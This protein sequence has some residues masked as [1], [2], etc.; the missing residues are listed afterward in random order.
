MASVVISGDT[1]GSVTITAPAVA[2]TPTLTLPTATDTLIGR[3]TTDTL[4]NKS[5]VASQLTGTIAGARMPA[6]S[7]LQ[8]VNATSNA[9]TTSSSTTYADTGLTVS[10]TPTSSTSKILVFVSINGGYKAGSDCALCTRLVRDSTAISNIDGMTLYTGSTAAAGGTVSFNYLDSPAT[11][12]ST[13][14]KVQMASSN[15]GRTVQINNYISF[16]GSVSA[17]TVMEISA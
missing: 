8:V 5:I 12:S 14:Y 6:G 16:V 2:G 7:V 13:T 1:S 10:I 9:G 17:I 11:T 3:A 4:T 15:A